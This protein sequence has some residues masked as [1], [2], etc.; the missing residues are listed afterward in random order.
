MADQVTRSIHRRPMGFDNVHFLFGSFVND[1]LGILGGR[2]P[3][4]SRG[5]LLLLVPRRRTV[6]MRWLLSPAPLLA[7]PFDLPPSRQ[8][9]PVCLYFRL[10]CRVC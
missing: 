9:F 10:V 1:V 2:S 7:M 4:K 3:Y 5:V 6:F 8:P